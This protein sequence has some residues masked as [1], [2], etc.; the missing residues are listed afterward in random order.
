MA[1]DRTSKLQNLLDASGFPYQLAVEHAVRSK[2]DWHNG[3]WSI[4]G[5]EHHWSTRNREGYIDIVLSRSSTHLVVE[6][7]RSRD[8]TWVFLI[9][10]EGQMNRSH[11]RV[12]WASTRVHRLPLS[13]WVD[14]QVHP[15]SP[16]SE[17]CVVRG[18]EN[19]KPLLE[20]IARG[21]TEAADGLADQ[22]LEL[23][24]QRTTGNVIVPVIVTNAELVVARFKPE[25][26]N[27]ESGEIES[28]DFDTVSHLRFRKSL[29]RAATP[30]PYEPESL[31]DLADAAVRT[32]FVVR[33]EYVST[34][35][36][37]FQTGDA[38]KLWASAR[39]AADGAT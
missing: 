21:V 20:S 38:G 18:Q 14:T 3:P 22:F 2:S 12:A 36:D 39:S 28:P 31:A 13:G 23:G 4:A 30:D 24:E 26:V 8:A 7:K 19:S 25:D 5:R 34:W 10:K 29:A 9:P 1:K 16:E 33:G 17:F 6:C 35:L 27:V 32:V 15:A 37:D 11:A